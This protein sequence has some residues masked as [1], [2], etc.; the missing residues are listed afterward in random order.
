MRIVKADLT[1]LDICTEILA[2]TELGQMYFIDRNDQY[3][4]KELL[5]EGF[6]KNE[7]DVCLN[8]DSECVGFCWIQINGIFHWFPF[9]HVVVT[10]PHFFGQ[11]IGC[12][13]MEHFERI[14]FEVDQSPKAF[15]MV[16]SYNSN[17]IRFYENR[18]YK[19]SG[20]IP[21]LFVKGIDEILMYKNR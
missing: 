10:D 2:Q 15:L 4:G 6:D 8:E 11:G 20:N 19:R 7:I 14:S 18:G 9:L 17:A 16:G 12:R 3:I 21:D 1:Y 13:M 5:K